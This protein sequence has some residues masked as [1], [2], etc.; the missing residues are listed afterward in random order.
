M[1][2]LEYMVGSDATIIETIRRLDEV[3]GRTIMVV[4]EKRR[5]LG[6][7]TDGDIRR[8][9]LAGRGLEDPI[10]VV[11][12]R[13]PRV[14]CP[15]DSRTA[16]LNMMRTMQLRQVPMVDYDHRVIGIETIDELVKDH[17]DRPNWVVLMAGGLGTRLHPLTEST[18]KPLLK[19]GDKPVLEIILERFVRHDF[20][21]FY[22]SVNYK[23]EMVKEY[24]GDGSDWGCEVRYLEENQRMGTAGGLSLIT[25][26]LVDP[27]LVMNGDLLTTLNFE[28][29]LEYHV[30]HAAQATIGVREYDFQVPFGVVKMDDHQVVGIDEKPVNRFFVNAGVYVLDPACLD[31]V[32]HGSY[33]DM[34]TLLTDLTGE[35]KSVVA[36]PIREY[37]LDIGRPDDFV[38]ANADYL[39]VFE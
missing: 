13:K 8:S 20:R 29:L 23:A 32:P 9:L 6:T 4:D 35:G 12:N 10:S 15:N 31:R 25:E 34:T 19:V 5:L 3:A 2:W 7:V 30:G 39:T 22:I 1:K 24:F 21:R 14:A 27:L 28:S 26:K 37:W 16:L 38:K 36:F 33:Y 17:E 18:P 11:M